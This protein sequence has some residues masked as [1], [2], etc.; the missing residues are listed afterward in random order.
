MAISANISLQ[1]V[2]LDFLVGLYPIK[3]EKDIRKIRVAVTDL[4]HQHAQANWAAIV[5]SE[6]DI[7]AR[8][9]YCTNNAISGFIDPQL[10]GQV[11]ADEQIQIKT[12]EC[13]D[14]SPD[15]YI[16]FFP[17][18]ER[19]FNGVFILCVDKEFVLRADFEGFLQNIWIGLKD[20]TRLVLTYYSTE[21]FATRFNAILGT[22][23]EGI[24]FVDDRGRDGWVNGAASELLQI[25]AEANASMVIAGAMQQLRGRAIN[26]DDIAKTGRE[27]FSSP[28]KTVKD[29]IWIFGEPI[30]RVLSV[31]CVPT[32][33][34][35]INGRLWVFSDITEIH[36]ANNQLKELNIELAEKRK[37]AEEQNKAKSDFLANMSHEIRTPMNGVIGMTS[38]L[39]STRLDEEQ[40]DYVDTIRISGEALLSIIN[41][42][43]DLSKIESGKMELEY[44]PF[45]IRTV[46]EE[47]FDLL[48]VKAN[49]K[50]LDLLYYIDPRVP[51]EI[52]G[53]ITRFRQILVNL[54]S[55][56]LKFTERGEVYVM[57]NLA[58]VQDN[59]YTL[60]FTVKDTGIGIPK[61]KYHRLFESFS[62]VDSSTTR[63]Y[64][65]T[66]LGLVICQRLV[67]LMGGSIR[68]ES[69]YGNG[70]SFIFTIK[71]EANR[72]AT[73]YNKKEKVELADLKGKSILILDDNKTNLKI[74]SGQCAIWGMKATTTDS[75]EEALQLINTNKFDLAIIDMLLPDT[76]GIEV[77]KLI[78][79]L[80]KDLPLILF[81]SAGYLPLKNE[82]IKELFAGVL[83]KPVKQSQIEET[84]ITVLSQHVGAVA[85][86]A[87]LTNKEG[88]LP[89]NILVAEDDLI[90]RKVIEKGLSKMGYAC[91]IVENGRLAV[92]QAKNK[93]YQLV[94]MDM[95]MPEM[96]GYEAAKLI[97]E[98]F[99]GNDKPVIIALT[100]N[101]LVEEK[102]KV[103]TTGMD[104]YI[105]K[106]Y[107]IQ[108]LQDAIDRWKDQLLSKIK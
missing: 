10:I 80:H 63:K 18:N 85:K 26:Q 77:A 73:L 102:E 12:G 107:K 75:H 76:N 42:I 51:S 96:D 19:R 71:A 101:A 62:Q 84:L 64:G 32:V 31:S 78:K 46:I 90:N 30:T 108:D 43:L 9:L 93:R 4:L 20:V 68:V 94:F 22:I 79:Q 99:P 66:G 24:V 8:V 103:L 25:P 97:S 27:L 50:G 41:D 39:T 3:M 34:E 70:A 72:D 83:H 5:R 15:E 45:T 11:L 69:E 23:Q 82:H 28:N 60:E 55:N 33:S 59:V 104:D 7:T 16:I 88:A 14:R 49:E 40:R 2:A 38:L 36:L 91:D 100:A 52:V 98:I 67:A 87:P 92:E 53:D 17:G 57:A 105:S 61:D 95:M 37:I 48:S 86:S 6:D 89:I 106:P 47:T 35:N 56:G 13:L 58:D 65:G 1:Q 81:S 74:F 21:Q 54:V 29:W 44:H